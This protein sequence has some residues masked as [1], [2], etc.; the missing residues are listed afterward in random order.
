MGL[1]DGLFMA[2]DLV[3]GGV[4]AFKATERL[5]ELCGQ[6]IDY[7]EGSLTED[8]T[9]LY[10]EYKALVKKKDAIEDADKQNEM[11]EDVEKALVSYLMSVST[12]PAISKKFASDIQSAIAEWQKCNDMPNEVFE[13]YMMKQAKTPEERE[14]VR[15]ILDEANAEE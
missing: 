1:F 9:K 11:T 8:N 15:K 2:V 5:E 13:K 4:A 10:E 6:S 3:K 12:N 7:Y 14:A